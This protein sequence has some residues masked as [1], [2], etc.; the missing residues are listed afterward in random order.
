MSFIDS[1]LTPHGTAQ[2]EHNNR[3]NDSVQNI[4]TK[5]ANS[6]YGNYNTNNNWY[7]GSV[8]PHQHQAIMDALN[9]YGPGGIHNTVANHLNDLWNQGQSQGTQAAGNY[10]SNPALANAVKMSF[11][12]NANSQG[13]DY[14]NQMYSPEGQSQ[15]LNSLM[16]FAN[17]GKADT[18]PLNMGASMVYGKPQT[19]MPSSEIGPVLGQ[20]GSAAVGAWGAGGF[21][22]GGGKK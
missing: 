18:G 4:G 16:G 22:R 21:G 5:L 7:Q 13:A 15:S 8:L 9:Q 3:V 2:A 6:A 19:Q 12:S 11:L 14:A 17:A 20:L 10:A 1:I